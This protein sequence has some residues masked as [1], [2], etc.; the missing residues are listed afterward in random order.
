MQNRLLILAKQKSVKISHT[1]VI[2]HYL[3]VGN[4]STV[5]FHSSSPPPISL[6]HSSQICNKHF[7]PRRKN[8]LGYSLYGQHWCVVQPHDSFNS[9]V[10]GT[11]DIS[12]SQ[13]TSLRFVMKGRQT[14][15]Y[16]HFRYFLISYEML[17]SCLKYV[18][19]ILAACIPK[20]MSFGSKLLMSNI[21]SY[22]G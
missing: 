8:T 4:V 5:A 19:S 10:G 3:T 14:H 21:I 15:I 7:L 13:S 9:N 11:A 17:P 12:H 18:P 20:T 1:L 22:T 6:S 2:I 16:A